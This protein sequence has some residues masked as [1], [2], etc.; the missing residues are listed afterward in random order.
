MGLGTLVILLVLVA[1]LV[2]CIAYE[3]R[4]KRGSGEVPCRL[5][6]LAGNPTSSCLPTVLYKSEVGILTKGMQVQ[7]HFLHFGFHLNYSF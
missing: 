1:D 3:A 7:S 6:S 5:G 2:V 4:C